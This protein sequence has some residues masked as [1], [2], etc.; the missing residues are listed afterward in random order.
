[1]ASHHPTN[2]PHSK[3]THPAPVNDPALFIAQLVH[4]GW[5]EGA[6]PWA[7]TEEIADIAADFVCPE[8]DSRGLELVVFYNPA[9]ER[10]RGFACCARCGYTTELCGYTT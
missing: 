9:A 7:D 6:P 1:M 8:C 10:W 4:N 2:R 3:Q 5:Q